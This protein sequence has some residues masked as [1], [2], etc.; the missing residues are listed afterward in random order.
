MGIKILHGEQNSLQVIKD[1][2]IPGE[3]CC[4]TIIY[5]CERGG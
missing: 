5:F 1:P 3:E 2:G 4:H